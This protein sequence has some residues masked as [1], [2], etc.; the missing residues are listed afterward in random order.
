[1]KTG[2]V[3][4]LF[5]DIEGSTALL[6][7]LGDAAYAAVLEQHHRNIRSSQE[8]FGGAEQGTEGDSFSLS[9]PR[10]AGA[11]ARRSRCSGSSSPTT[12]PGGEELRVPMGI[13]TG[14]ESEASTG[15]VGDEVL[16]EPAS[17]RSCFKRADI[18]STGGW[19]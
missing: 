9:S 17:N 18:R 12:G 1:M 7:R 19:G 16:V 4:F 8:A 14:E 10:R 6:S 15:M 11:S 2:T 5:T 13:H 3:T